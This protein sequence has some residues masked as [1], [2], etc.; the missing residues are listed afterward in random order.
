M[1][2]GCV[3]TDAGIMGLIT[4]DT[5]HSEMRAQKIHGSFPGTLLRREGLRKFFS[6][7]LLHTC[8]TSVLL[9]LVYG[10]RCGI[11]LLLS[12]LR[13]L[14][15]SDTSTLSSFSHFPLSFS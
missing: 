4:A 14:V 12:S 8:K 6:G 2:A 10:L 5:A 13:W 11:A 15:A 1:L 9:V 7:E 3:I